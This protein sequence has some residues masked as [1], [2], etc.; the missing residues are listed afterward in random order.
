MQIYSVGGDY[1]KNYDLAVLNT[2]GTNFVVKTHEMNATENLEVDNNYETKKLTIGCEEG[3]I[4]EI[5]F[6]VEFEYNEA[7]EFFNSYTDFEIQ[8]IQ[9]EGKSIRTMNISN[10]LKKEIEDE[11]DSI[12]NEMSEEIHKD[13]ERIQ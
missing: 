9:I 8:D 1:Y 12:A 13:D 4:F 2:I 6:D 5:E 3:R 11:V 7:E 10:Q